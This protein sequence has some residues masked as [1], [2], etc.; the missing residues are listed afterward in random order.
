[1]SILPS[2]KA[3]IPPSRRGK[4]V[5]DF[6]SRIVHAFAIQTDHDESDIHPQ[7]ICTKCIRKCSHAQKDPARREKYLNEPKITWKP[8]SHT[9]TC[10]LC[11]KLQRS[12]AGGNKHKKCPPHLKNPLPFLLTNKNIFQK[13]EHGLPDMQSRDINNLAYK[14]EFK[15]IYSCGIHVCRMI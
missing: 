7:Q 9:S 15:N 2:H 12:T 8:H 5:D 14:E 4:P 1:M 6:K 13:F 11:L 3:P 10:I